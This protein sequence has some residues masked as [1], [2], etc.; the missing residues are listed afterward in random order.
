MTPSFK[1]VTATNEGNAEAEKRQNKIG[2]IS[3][4][5]EDRKCTEINKDGN[6]IGTYRS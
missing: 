2:I 1:L 4:P 6:R 5:S 3:S